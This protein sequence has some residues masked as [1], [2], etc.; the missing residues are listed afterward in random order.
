MICYGKC[1]YSG[2]LT[3]FAANAYSDIEC[4]V[5]DYTML[6][7]PFL[8][9]IRAVVRVRNYSIQTEKV[10]VGWAK[11]F[12]RF[13]QNKHPAEL[14][15]SE[16]IAYLTYLAV[17]RNV[18]ASSQ[19]QAL[20]ALV[21]MY[22][23]VVKK[24]L[25]DITTAVRAKLPKKLPVVLT[26]D[27]VTLLLRGLDGVHRLIGSLLYGSGLRISECIRLR[28]KHI[29]FNYC[30]LHIHNAKGQKDRIVTL[31][32]QLLDPL[33]LQISQVKQLHAA[34]LAD[35]YGNVFMPNALQGKFNAASRSLPWQYV[36]PSKTLSKD[37]GSGEARRHHQY[38][39]TFQKVF[40]SAVKNVDIRKAATPHTL[41]HSFATHSLENGLD[42]RTVQQQLG[43]S[44]PETTEI[45]THVLRRGSDA[46]RSP[47]EDIFPRLAYD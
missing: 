23:Y 38:Q 22:R 13:H 33:E 37:P 14:H 40:R 41:R 4:A 42:I 2:S 5:Y 20:N 9:E 16:V 11:R 46:V 32:P 21:F 1:D 45:Y 35:G 25:G 18:S 36:F 8:N 28:V 26:R 19:N 24:P 34:D 39:S 17:T 27:E 44:S 10:Y 30:L 7:S 43:H 12:I 29:D 15:D 47:L 31:A 3:R 6:A